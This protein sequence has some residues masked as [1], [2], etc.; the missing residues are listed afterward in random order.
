M[1]YPIGT[2]IRYIFSPPCKEFMRECDGKIGTL[3]GIKYNSPLIFIPG[4]LHISCYST[5][6]VPATV[7]CAWE[8]IESIEPNI[9]EQLEFDFMKE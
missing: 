9:G 5:V 4:A 2:K 6:S 1:K 8:N 3:V 7:Q